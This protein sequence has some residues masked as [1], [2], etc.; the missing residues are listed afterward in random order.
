MDSSGTHTPSAAEPSTQEAGGGFYIAPRNWLL[1]ALFGGLFGLWLTGDGAGVVEERAVRPLYD[2]F[3]TRSA[4][5]V[6]LER[7][8]A[9]AV[10]TG[11]V[12]R[13][14][15]TLEPSPD[16]SGKGNW[17]IEELFGAKA[18]R[19]R[20]ERLLSRIGS[21]TTL[22]LVSADPARHDEYGLTA[23]RALRVRVSADAEVGE[24]S[25]VDL[26]L[27]PA[28]ERGAWVRK[29]GESEV[30]RIARFSPP[31]PAPLAWFDDS[32]LMPLSDRGIR[33]I[34]A[35]G[36]ALPKAVEVRFVPGG[37]RFVDESGVGWDVARV[38]DLQSRLQTLFPT[39]VT[40]LKAAGAGL[41]PDAGADDEPWLRL[42]IVPLLTGKSFHIELSEPQEG[43]SECA[44][45]L[46]EGTTRVTVSSSTVK[47]VAASLVGLLDAQGDK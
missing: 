6:V 39:N 15:L 41:D 40:G 16:A 10:A 4:R 24:S 32:S 2:A 21:M 30:W 36:T 43:A 5:N 19:D 14:S 29:F 25:I 37:E 47:K 33:S 34:G 45:A 13:A 38:L 11:G 20:V 26:L 3:N 17:V 44:A 8:D 35:T 46:M 7:A 23:E 42:K 18:F 22:E 1:L 27:A 9:A 12:E 28:P 31:S